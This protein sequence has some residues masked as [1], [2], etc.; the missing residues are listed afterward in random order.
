VLGSSAALGAVATSLG[1]TQVQKDEG[2]T[3]SNLVEQLGRKAG[4]GPFRNARGEHFLAVGDAREAFLRSALKHCE[5]LGG[6][7]IKHLRDKGFRLEFPARPL[8]VVALK[9]QASYGALL[10]EAPGKDVGGHYDLETNRLVMFD[11]RGGPKGPAEGAERLNLFTLVHE[12]THQLSFNAGLFERRNPPPLCL[13]EGIATYAELWQPSVKNSIG[14]INR[15]RLQELGDAGT[16][17]PIADLLSNDKAFRGKDE[18]LAYAESWL[19]THH[20]LRSST[21]VPKFRD[22][23]AAIRQESRPER[24]RSVAE[25]RLGPLDRLDKVIKDEARRYLNA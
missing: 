23:L 24:A 25:Q 4:L 10:G 19:F 20:F 15:P 1:S 11:F 14:G 2:D 13:S 16:W 3:E 17:I 12:T 9:D 21:R 18:H 5:A 22:F 6:A 7:F 8:T